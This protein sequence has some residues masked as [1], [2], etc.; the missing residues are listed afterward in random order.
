MTYVKGR[1][2]A[3]CLRD[4]MRSQFSFPTSALSRTPGRSAAGNL[5]KQAMLS[6]DTAYYRDR[7]NTE[8]RLALTADRQDVAL[9]HEELARMY[10][11]LVDQKELRP[12]LRMVYPDQVTTG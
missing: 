4:S 1:Q 7:A 3:N 5:G 2:A 11:A 8:R 9:I 6:S 12:T 10:Q